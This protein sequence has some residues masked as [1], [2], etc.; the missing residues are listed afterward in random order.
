MSAPY[1]CDV[2][3]ELRDDC[4]AVSNAQGDASV[5]AKCRGVD[6]WKPQ[7]INDPA[8]EGCDR[9]YLDGEPVSLN[10]ECLCV[11]CQDEEREA[12]AVPW[13]DPDMC[14]PRGAN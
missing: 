2:C 13:Y 5:C 10:R 8:C 11:R 3:G 9:Y 6:D 1:S 14:P 4:H 7:D 12:E